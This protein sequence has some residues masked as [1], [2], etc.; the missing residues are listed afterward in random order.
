MSNKTI[1]A[2]VA[3][4]NR[5]FA[6]AIASTIDNF[7][8]F[9]SICSITDLDNLVDALGQKS[10]D[11]L[12]LDVN[13]N[14]QSSLD[15]VDKIKELRPNM[16]IVSLTTMNNSFLKQE[17]LSKGVD[18]FLG[19]DEC[20]D[21]LQTKLLEIIEEN[22]PCVSLQKKHEFGRE[23]F[24]ERQLNIIR[25][26]YEF[27]SEKE[28]AKSLFISTSTLK[29]HKQ[30]LFLKTNTNNNLELVKFGIRQGIIVV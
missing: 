21:D 20:F 11:L 8:N 10:P 29:T 9:E 28:V 14:G 7:E 16:C 13:F 27:N 17:A 4:D 2:I 3:D 30:K 6:E 15:Y 18:G 24:T 25:A 26:L 22:A 12:V 5:F 1:K 19:K 23:V